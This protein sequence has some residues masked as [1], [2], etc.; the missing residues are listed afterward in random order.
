MADESNRGA[1]WQRTHWRHDLQLAHVSV[2]IFVGVNVTAL[3]LKTKILLRFNGDWNSA[4]DA[5]AFYAAMRTY[6]MKV[7]PFESMFL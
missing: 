6:D 2:K 5:M 1:G 3:H 4:E 7:R